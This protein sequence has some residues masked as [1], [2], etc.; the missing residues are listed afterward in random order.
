V[1][2]ERVYDR[3]TERE[4]RSLWEE[5]REKNWGSQAVRIPPELPTASTVAYSESCGGRKEATRID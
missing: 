3:T 4:K 1:T 5:V 2:A